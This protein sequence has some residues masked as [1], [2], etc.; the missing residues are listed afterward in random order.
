M[1]LLNPCPLHWWLFF[2]ILVVASFSVP[3]LLDLFI[4]YLLCWLL[5]LPFAFVALRSSSHF[6]QPLKSSLTFAA[7]LLS[8]ISMPRGSARPHGAESPPLLA[9]PCDSPRPIG[10]C[11]VSNPSS[12]NS[13][14]G[15]HW[16]SPSFSLTNHGIWV[17]YPS[18]VLKNSNVTSLMSSL[19]D[20]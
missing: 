4:F 14:G 2:C 5:S 13:C 20:N 16:C 9:A 11:T 8:M 1:F 17:A 19:K 18:E 6:P 15:A 3:Q 12:A 10:W 7:C